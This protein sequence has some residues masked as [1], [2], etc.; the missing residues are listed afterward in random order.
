M[1]KILVIDLGSV[2]GGQEIYS[3]NLVNE[4]VLNGFDVSHASSQLKHKKDNI[5]FYQISFSM[6]HLIC[7][8]S[9]LNKLI[10]SNDIVVFNV[11]RAIQQSFFL[12]KKK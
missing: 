7:N 5:A 12:A 1:I 4:F 11:N 2:W 3:E 10:K 9:L 8:I 6:S